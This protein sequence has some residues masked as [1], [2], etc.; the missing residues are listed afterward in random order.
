MTTEPKP[1]RLK[2]P[3]ESI[4]K[5]QGSGNRLKAALDDIVK[6]EA[7]GQDMSS[8]RADLL[9]IDNKRKKI[10]ALFS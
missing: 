5:L 7:L 8:L 6:L 3:P 10:L 4:T 9:D 2:L 1:L